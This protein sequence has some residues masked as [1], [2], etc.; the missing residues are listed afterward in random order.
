M[1][2]K[3]R[4]IVLLCVSVFVLASCGGGDEDTSASTTSLAAPGSVATTAVSTTASEPSTTDL[5]TAT[6]STAGSIDGTEKIEVVF[7]DGRSWAFDGSCTYT[8][9][10]TGPASSLWNIEAADA[11]DGSAFNAI[12]AFPFDPAN[13]TPVLIGT[14]VDAEENVYVFIES[15]D[16]SDESNLILNVGLHDGVL[17]TVGDPIDISATVTC[18]L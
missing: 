9:D 8:P 13:T 5:E 15:E 10:S 16:V 3:N 4:L 6:T 17:K 14:M 18:Q 2:P 12:M 11:T 7:D 1:V